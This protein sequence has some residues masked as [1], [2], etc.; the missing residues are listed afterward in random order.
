MRLGVFERRELYA[1]VLAGQA[2]LIFVGGRAA[3]TYITLDCPIRA[4]TGW[5]CPGCGST[6]C[7]SAIASG[8]LVGGA[9]QNP[10]LFATFSGLVLLSVIGML[11]PAR[12]G[13]LFAWYQR[14]RVETAVVA[15][16]AM[17]TF[18]VGRNLLA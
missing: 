2:G 18:T 11:S 13:S 10:L 9:R 8:D 4:M 17:V 7:V 5:Q 15:I 14:A 6:R 16:A 3:E 12:L 1:T